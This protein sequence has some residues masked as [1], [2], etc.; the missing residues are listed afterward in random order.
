MGKEDITIS[1]LKLDGLDS[2]KTVR[3]DTTNLDEVSLKETPEGYLEGYA[4]ATRTGVF[5]YMKSDGSIQREL[6]LPEEVFKDDAVNSFK[7]LPITNDHPEEAVSSTNVKQLN[8]GT[9]GQDVKQDQTY[10]APYV[11]IMDKDA[12]ALVKSGKRGLSFGYDVNLV[13]KDGVYKGEKY[14]Y[15]QTDIKGNHLAIVFQGRAGDKARLRLDGQEAECV[16][17]NFDNINNENLIMKKYKLD[18]KEIEVSEEVFLKLDTLETTTTSLENKNKD[19]T[20][21]LDSLEGEKDALK[22]KKDA[23]EAEIVELSKKDSDAEIGEKVKAR[24]S[25]EKKCAT[26]L[27]K[28]E[29]ISSFSGAEL[30]SKVI[31]AI[32]PD[33]KADGKSEDYI[34]ARF[35]AILDLKKDSNLAENFKAASRRSD[36]T[37]SKVSVSNSDLQTGLIN[38]STLNK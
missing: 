31:C 12:V 29:D 5:K 2:V 38:R 3:Y 23:L 14:D 1:S 20:T 24:I 10:L 37:E 30:R 11:K 13:K 17:N 36:S 28:D 32:S 6:R 25:L 4:I 9:T 15:V 26:F 34:T 21:K 8:V 16:F 19:L 7:M 35:D 22:T 27:K 18:G 33:F